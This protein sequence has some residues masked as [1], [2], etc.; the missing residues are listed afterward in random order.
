[1]G[2]IVE[3]RLHGEREIDGVFAALEEWGRRPDAALWYAMCFVEGAKGT[4]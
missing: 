2:T 3:H 4:A 1:M